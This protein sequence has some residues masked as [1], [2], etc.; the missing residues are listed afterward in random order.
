MFWAKQS[1]VNWT[2][3]D[4]GSWRSWKESKL[5][6]NGGHGVIGKPIS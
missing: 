6:L 3:E 5:G 4:I 2:M 1:D